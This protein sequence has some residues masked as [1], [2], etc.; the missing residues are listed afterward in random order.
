[1]LESHMG[2]DLEMR[3]MHKVLDGVQESLDFILLE[4]DL[5]QDRLPCPQKHTHDTYVLEPPKHKT[6]S[7]YFCE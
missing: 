6:A 7:K 3:I 2:M 1:M 4:C 5:T